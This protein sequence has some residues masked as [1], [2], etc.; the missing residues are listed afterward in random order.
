MDTQ[1]SEKVIDLYLYTRIATGTKKG[2]FGLKESMLFCLR[3]SP[4]PPGDLM[5]M[6]GIQKTNLALLAKHCLDDGLI[7]KS[8]RKNDNRAIVYSITDKGRA[9]LQKTLERIEQRFSKVTQ[10]QSER[11]AA[12]E[13]LDAATSFMSFV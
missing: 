7:A 11:E 6:L 13:S 9:E 1:L 8:F 5:T 3:N 4:Q 10:S 2:V 12:L